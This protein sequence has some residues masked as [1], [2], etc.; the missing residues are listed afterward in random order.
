MVNK[1][2]ILIVLGLLFIAFLIFFYPTEKRKIKKLLKNTAEWA[3]KS[4]DDTALAVA[5]KSKRSKNFFADK[6]LL[7]IEKRDLEREVALED[8][9]RGYLFLMSSNDYFKVKITDIDIEK[10]EDFSAEAV[11]TVLIEAKGGTLEEFSN[12]NEVSFG[13]TKKE[14]G[15]RINKIEIKEVLEK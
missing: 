11:A 6:V 10:I 13:F 7:K 9:E 1:K 8:I 14:E 12:V 2:N 4:K 5:V 15:W 3:Q